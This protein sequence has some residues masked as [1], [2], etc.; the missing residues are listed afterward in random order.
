MNKALIAIAAAA[1]FSGFAAQAASITNG[2]LEGYG[3]DQFTTL[4]GG[5]TSIPGW[6]V[7]GDSVDWI[8]TYWVAEDGGNSVDLT[9]AGQGTLSTDIAG[10]SIGATYDVSFYLAGNP[11]GGP[12]VK[13]VGVDVGGA[14]N[15]YTFDTTFASLG[16]MGWTLEV[17][18]FTATGTSQTLTFASQD[19]GYYGPALDNVS[20]ALAPVPIPA[21]GLLLMG[22]LGALG[23]LRRRR[24]AV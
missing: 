2:S 19:G 11:A 9:G 23:A 5:D 4:S 3:G 21:A 15:F 1:A 22:G 17:F 13:T 8:S 24:R 14:Q 6:T 16:D 20:I 7:G 10:L 12:V 18:T